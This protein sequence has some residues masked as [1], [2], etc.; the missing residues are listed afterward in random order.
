MSTTESRIVPAEHPTIKQGE[1]EFGFDYVL[2]RHQTGALAVEA[3][4]LGAESGSPRPRVAARLDASHRDKRP[5]TTARSIGAGPNSFV[6]VEV[7]L[8]ATSYGRPATSIRV[9][10]TPEDAANLAEQIDAAAEEGSR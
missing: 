6:T 7:T 10:L 8:P 1:P 9:Y 4:T 2:T 5:T 3:W